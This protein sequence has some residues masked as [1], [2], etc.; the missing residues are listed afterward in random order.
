MILLTGAT[1]YIGRRLLRALAGRDVRCIARRPEA[2]D[3]APGVEVVRGDVLDPAAL[4]SAMVGVTTAYYLVHSMAD[5]GSFA[6]RD[7]RAAEAFGAAARAAGVRRIVYLGGL[8]HEPGLSAHLSSR[9]EVGRVLA[10]SGVPVVELRASIVIG[11]GSLPFELARRL[12]EKLT[13]MLTPRWVRTAAQPI[14]VDDVVAYL[15]E[16]CDADLPQGGVFEIGGAERVS[17]GGLMREI[18]R[19]RGLRRLML[20]VPV[21]SPGLSARWLRLVAPRE[22]HVG[23]SLIE[24]VRNETV[25]RDPRAL[26]AFGV[27]PLGLSEAVR[28]ALVGTPPP[29][30][31]TTGP[32]AWFA[33]LG[34]VLTCLAVGALGGLVT[35]AAIPTWYATLAKPTWTPPGWLFGPVWTAL[36]VAMAVAAWRLWRRDGLVEERLPLVLFAL[37]L[38][39]NGAWSW[40]F[41]GARAPCA[42]LVE[43][44]FLWL[45]VAAATVF[46]FPRDR[47]A[48]WLYVPYLAWVTFAT[49]LNASICALAA[50]G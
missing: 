37:Q 28:R 34:I 48:G 1:G 9:Q 39:L 13:V 32:R 50:A 17:Y 36:Y 45:A 42:A 30:A 10:A 5:E 24:G 43:I 22:A 12:V 20:R 11:A 29:A 2:V 19:Q 15:V 7:R 26:A 16:A 40:I 38:L 6:E 18:A 33:L 35:S 14:A 49:A 31:P 4:A 3:A 47:V 25:V 21:L 44:V 46:T 27:R 41:F 8:G 23:R